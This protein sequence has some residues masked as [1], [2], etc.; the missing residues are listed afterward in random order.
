MTERC[1]YRLERWL[2]YLEIGKVVG[3]VCADVCSLYGTSRPAGD[4]AHY[5]AELRKV[6]GWYGETLATHG[7]SWA[8]QSLPNPR[9]GAKERRWFVCTGG[10]PRARRVVGGGVCTGGGPRAR[11][12]VGG[13]GRT[14]V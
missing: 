5:W 9:E 8:G 12:A 6:V 3:T 13:G 4:F 2:V 14:E 7:A 11:R 1:D 10:G